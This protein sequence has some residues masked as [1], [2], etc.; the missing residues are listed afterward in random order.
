MIVAEKNCYLREKRRFSQTMWQFVPFEFN[1]IWEAM[2]EVEFAGING[3]RSKWRS[4]ATLPRLLMR[5]MATG[6]NALLY[7]GK[8]NHFFQI[9]IKYSELV[10]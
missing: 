4:G 10:I 3:G 1:S 2:A 5:P 9:A 6:T 7:D 8:N